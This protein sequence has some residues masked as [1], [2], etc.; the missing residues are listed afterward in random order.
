MRY[1]VDYQCQKPIPDIRKRPLAPL[2]E[3][4]DGVTLQLAAGLKDGCE[5]RKAI[6]RALKEADNTSEWFLR[7][8][9]P[10]HQDLRINKHLGAGGA[11]TPRRIQDPEGAKTIVVS[12]K[13]SAG[14]AAAVSRQHFKIACSTDPKTGM[15][16]VNKD[17]TLGGG[18]YPQRA[19]T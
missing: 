13:T 1:G 5:P 12:Y 16:K 4:V 8:R 11:M 3:L 6:D 7:I 9:G 18:A 14:A 17:T 2:E 10:C 15:L 19:R